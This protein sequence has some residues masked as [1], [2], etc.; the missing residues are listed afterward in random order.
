MNVQS[1]SGPRAGQMTLAM[2]AM[3][4][5]NGPRVLRIGKVLGG[6]VIEERVIK[7][8]AQ[9][10]IGS[11]HDCTFVV[12]GVER[13]VLFESTSSGYVLNV[14]PSMRGRAALRTGLTELAGASRIALDSD[15]RG[16]VV[17][18]D[19]T[20]LFQF[21]DKAPVQPKPQL[22]L[23][24]E[25]AS[26]V[27][28][29]FAI[30]AAFSFLLHFGFAGAVNSDWFDPTIDDGAETASLITETRDRPSPPTVEEKNDSPS[31]SP[32]KN[33]DK[34]PSPS[35]TPDKAAPG[36]KTGPGPTR[37]ASPDPVALSQALDVLEVKAIGAIGTNGPAQSSLLKPGASVVDSNLDKVAEKGSG[38]GTDDHL[39]VPGGSTAPIG[40]GQ[41]G[42]D[43]LAGGFNATK[44]G[45]AI[46]VVDKSDQ[47]HVPTTISTPKPDV[48]NVKDVDSVIARNRWRFKACYDK[49][50]AKDANAAGTVRVTVRVGEG[51]EVTSASAGGDAPSGLTECVRLAFTQMKFSS[52]DG[53]SAQFTAPVVLS[54]AKK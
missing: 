13:C 51:G 45:P 19:T 4:R 35:P 42:K 30:I 11:S 5:P 38:V 7:E 25:N 31:P 39:K 29:G 28:W 15:S 32:D 54:T 40:P 6:R 17:V 41:G 34:A 9:V 14:G 10:T 20:F 1:S 43:G 48:S 21:V 27:D 12:S 46:A 50:L 49:E 26:R 18:G 22:P 24:I 47:V 37:S 36:P 8:R 44:S 53:G 3:P 33:A 16:K 2:R 23:G 52:P